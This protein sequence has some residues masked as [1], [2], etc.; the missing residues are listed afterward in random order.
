MGLFGNMFEKKYCDI[1]GGEIGFLGNRKLADGNMC[2]SC[3]S[4]LSPWFDQRRHSTVQQIEDQLAYREE[5]R[6]FVERFQTTRSFGEKQHLLLDDN[7]GWF[8]IVSTQNLG[9]EN[10]DIFDFGDFTACRLDIQEWHSEV[11]RE[12]ES[13][14]MVSYSPPRYNYH[15]DFNIIINVQ[16]PY[17]DR[18]K[19]TLNPNTISVISESASAS[20]NTEA[21]QQYK[22][23]GS[24]IC[25]VLRSL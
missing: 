25:E 16:T 4:K 24:K 18:V 13:G 14:N 17:F 3:A 6:S 23:M 7:H 5:N 21:Y 19:F 12:D 11:K 9:R 10:P 20:T 1:C 15:Y 2:K 22:Q 8:T